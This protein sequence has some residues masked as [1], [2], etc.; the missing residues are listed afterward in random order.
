MEFE[1]VMSLGDHL[2]ELRR[3]LLWALLGLVPLFIIGLV[4]GGPLLEIVLLP[5][6]AALKAAGEPTGLQATS[7]FE[8]ISAYLKIAIVFALLLSTPWIILQTWLFVSPG[9]RPWER[10][11]VYLLIPLSG[12]LTALGLLFLYYVLLPATLTFLIGFGS[13]IVR[14]DPRHAPVPEGI[15]FPAVPVLAADPPVEIIGCEEPGCI[16]IGAQWVNT[17]LSEL[18]TVVGPGEVKSLRLTGGGAI[19]QEYRVGEYVSLFFLLGVILA[20]A[21]Q[22]PLVLM[23]LSWVGILVPSDLTPHR[24]KILFAC[25]IAGALMPS[26]DPIT[27]VILWAVFYGLFE[28]GIL[29]MRFVPARVVAGRTA[30][31]LTD[32]DRDDE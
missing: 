26:Q 28:V 6:L 23:I 22:L 4:F 15:V 10:R 19:R 21:F 24:K 13:G 11:F 27:M 29:L 14:E 32:G 1:R 31:K 20:I 2:D 18:R 7:P 30:P 8:T 25:A 3:R 5:L 12:L 16:P 17:T 9:L